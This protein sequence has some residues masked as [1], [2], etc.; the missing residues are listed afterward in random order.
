MN[1][2]TRRGQKWYWKSAANRRKS[3]KRT[4]KYRL[5]WR[6]T[7]ICPRCGTNPVTDKIHCESCLTLSRDKQKE[8][9]ILNAL[10]DVCIIC[11][12]ELE[13]KTKVRC[14]GCLKKQRDQKQKK[15]DLAKIKD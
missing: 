6:A 10:G 9:R 13:D 8:R 3:T 5:R 7:K 2:N 11:A 12:N 1:P 14:A 4:R 15:R